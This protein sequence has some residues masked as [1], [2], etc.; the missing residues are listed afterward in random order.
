MPA[1]ARATEMRGAMF[2]M[3]GASNDV[4]SDRG[5]VACTGDDGHATGGSLHGDAHDLLDF[6]RRQ[7]VQLAGA[8]CGDNCTEGMLRHRVDVALERGQ[9]EREVLLERR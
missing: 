5:V 9:V 8:A 6:V 4:G 3:L 7:R 1:L 2:E